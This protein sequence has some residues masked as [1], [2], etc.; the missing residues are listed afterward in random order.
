MSPSSTFCSYFPFL[1][2]SL[3]RFLLRGC[4]TPIHIRIS[5]C[6]SDIS[7]VP[8]CLTSIN[9]QLPLSSFNYFLYVLFKYYQYFSPFTS[10][11]SS[12]NSM[13]NVQSNDDFRFL[14]FL[15][16]PNYCPALSNTRSYPIIKSPVISQISGSHVLHFQFHVNPTQCPAFIYSVRSN[17]KCQIPIRFFGSVVL[18]QRADF[19]LSDFRRIICII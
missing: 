17:M 14:S 2:C 13:P 16:D 10:K 19:H 3:R 4:F 11:R 1:P 6:K 8:K 9:L 12:S 7:N 5:K 15:P 18:L